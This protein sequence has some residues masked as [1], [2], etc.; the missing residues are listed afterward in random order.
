METPQTYRIGIQSTSILDLSIKHIRTCGYDYINSRSGPVEKRGILAA[1][2][3]EQTIMHGDRSKSQDLLTCWRAQNQL[4]PRQ[5]C[6]GCT[7]L[8]LLCKFINNLIPLLRCGNRPSSRFSQIVLI[9][10]W[11]ELIGHQLNGLSGT[12]LN[13]TKDLSIW[14]LKP[15]THRELVR[16][17]KCFNHFLFPTSDERGPNLPHSF[18][19]FIRMGRTL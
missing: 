7:L 5:G 14:A 2:M 9:C 16:S 10:I 18:F 13:M 15:L 17:F 11:A 6:T 4:P 19:I 8:T 3:G 12:L 1:N